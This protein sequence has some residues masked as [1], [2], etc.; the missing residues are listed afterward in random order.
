M[1]RYRLGY[2]A[3]FL[4]VFL[5]FLFS[6]NIYF[7]WLCMFLLIFPMLLYLTL[8]YET[9][10]LCVECVLDGWGYR[11]TDIKMK[12][13]IP[14]RQSFWGA[15]FL[16]ITFHVYNHLLGEEYEETIYIYLKEDQQEY[17]VI[18]HPVSCGEKSVTVKKIGLFDVFGLCQVALSCPKKQVLMVYPK[19]LNLSVDLRQNHYGSNFGGERTQNR[20]GNDLSEVFDLKEYHAGDD[21][22]AIHWKLSSKSD[23][24][25]IREA[26]DTVYLN[27]L[28]LFDAGKPDQNSED[29]LGAMDIT[30]TISQALFRQG[31]HHCFGFAGDVEMNM[32]AVTN[33]HRWLAVMTKWMGTPLREKNAESL[34]QFLAM[35]ME[36][37]FS[38]ILYITAGE[39]PDEI[40][41]INPKIE[42][43]AVC[44]RKE[45]EQITSSER[46][47]RHIMNLPVKVLGQEELHISF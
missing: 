41:K 15:G 11:D 39:C 27:T 30:A 38:R 28:V 21:V 13:K 42:V 9:K 17:D 26:S 37:P 31:I 33:Q 7:G 45:G 2:A 25:M 40:V 1:K 14:K 34:Q 23:H 20:K 8:L 36:Q 10:R 4:A 47:S 5:L 43:T 46:G 22:R 19:S 3:A 6:E 44:I 29:L 18:R 35:P 32:Q 24:L 12:V 16:G